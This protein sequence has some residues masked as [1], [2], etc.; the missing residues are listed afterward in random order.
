VAKAT[1]PEQIAV[2]VRG[3]WGIENKLYY[4]SPTAK[5][6]HAFQDSGEIPGAIA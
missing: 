4:A 1:G 2:H 3:H 5:T 6:A